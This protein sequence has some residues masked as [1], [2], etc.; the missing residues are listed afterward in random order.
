MEIEE[1]G[2]LPSGNDEKSFHADYFVQ[3][4]PLTQTF[5]VAKK[6]GRDKKISFPPAA[7]L[8]GKGMNQYPY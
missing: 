5:R 3:L 8:N 4:N 6:L 1:K 7:A 2:K